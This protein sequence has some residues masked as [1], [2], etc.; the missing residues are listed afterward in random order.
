MIHWR[1]SRSFWGSRGSILWGRNPLSKGSA[2]G[3]TSLSLQPVGELWRVVPAA[4]LVAGLHVQLRHLH[5][6]TASRAARHF[7]GGS[8]LKLPGGIGGAA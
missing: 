8:S 4:F 3:S 6:R 5:F 7:R 1:W 2:F